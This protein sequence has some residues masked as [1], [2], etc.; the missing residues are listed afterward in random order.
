MSNDSR[1]NGVDLSTQVVECGATVVLD[2]SVIKHGIVFVHPELPLFR[3][4]IQVDVANKKVSHYAFE[5]I[6]ATSPLVKN[7]VIEIMGP[8]AQI[9][10]PDGVPVSGLPSNG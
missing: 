8:D 5:L 1:P 3:L 10:R 2:D 7:F 6:K 4:V 9:V